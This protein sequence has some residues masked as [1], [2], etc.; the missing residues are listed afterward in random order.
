MSLFNEK[1]NSRFLSLK[2]DENEEDPLKDNVLFSK[3]G[4]WVKGI[5]KKNSLKSLTLN[6]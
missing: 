1:K 6:F 5:Q 2:D 4:N 3:T